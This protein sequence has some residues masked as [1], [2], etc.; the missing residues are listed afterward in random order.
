MPLCRQQNSAQGLCRQQNSEQGASVYKGQVGD[1]RYFAILVSDSLSV[2]LIKR[3][4]TGIFLP[5]YIRH[6]VIVLL[7]FASLICKP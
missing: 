6:I 5:R 1:V 3:N 7:V 4:K 2:H